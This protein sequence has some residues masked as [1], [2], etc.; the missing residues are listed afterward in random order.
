MIK[1]RRGLISGIIA[2]NEEFGS[3]AGFFYAPSPISRTGFGVNGE[4]AVEE[5]GS[6]C[7]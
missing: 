2:A 4:S 1:A 3:V 6:R 5:S 7:L